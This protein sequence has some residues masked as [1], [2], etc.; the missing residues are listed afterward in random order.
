MGL[1]ENVGSLWKK[2][3]NDGKLR[4]ESKQMADQVKYFLLAGYFPPERHDGRINPPKKDSEKRLAYYRS[5]GLGYCGDYP[6]GDKVFEQ[7]VLSGD[8]RDECVCYGDLKRE[9][10]YI[11]EKLHDNTFKPEH[12][13]VVWFGM[14]PRVLLAV[15]ESKG[16]DN[17]GFSYQD[18]GFEGFREDVLSGCYGRRGI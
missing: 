1:Y 7:D 13:F 15:R 17:Y 3:L 2:A 12:D 6:G 11:I 16:F 8:Q 4:S 5:H 9:D 10:A 18:G 14:R